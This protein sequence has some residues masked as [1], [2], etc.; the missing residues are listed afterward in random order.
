MKKILTYDNFYALFSNISNTAHLKF[1]SVCLFLTQIM[2]SKHLNNIT[3]IML[4][5][6]ITG[7]FYNCTY[8][9]GCMC[10]CLHVEHFFQV[11]F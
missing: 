3:I 10:V 8:I 9:W 7:L 11:S 2:R 4:Q 5:F 6:N 1:V